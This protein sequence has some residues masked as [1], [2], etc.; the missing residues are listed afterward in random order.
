MID[1]HNKGFLTDKGLAKK[2]QTNVNTIKTIR[3]WGGRQ[4]KINPKHT[5]KNSYKSVYFSNISLA[6]QHLKYLGYQESVIN[7]MIL[8]VN[9]YNKLTPDQKNLFK[10]ISEQNVADRRMPSDEELD[11]IKPIRYGD[12]KV[13]E[14]FRKLLLILCNKKN[15]IRMDVKSIN[16]LERGLGIWIKLNAQANL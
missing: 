10:T 4:L 15:E 5:F 12:D 2:Y 11:E 16:R 7:E 1:D 14:K 3:A 13:N 9:Q 8:F 6:K